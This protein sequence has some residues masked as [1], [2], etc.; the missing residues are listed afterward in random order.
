[1]PPLRGSVGGASLRVSPLAGRGVDDAS[2]ALGP[3]Q[4]Y[5][6][7]AGVERAFE[8]RAHDRREVLRGYLVE[9]AIAGD[10][11]VVDEDVDLAVGVDGRADDLSGLVEISD[12]VVVGGRFSA[13]LPDERDDLIGGGYGASC[14]VALDAGVV[15]DDLGALGSEG[16]G[17][18]SAYAATGAGND[19]DLALQASTSGRDVVF[20]HRGSPVSVA[21]KV[22]LGDEGGFG[23]ARKHGA[24]Q[25]FVQFVERPRRA[26]ASFA[27]EGARFGGVAVAGDFA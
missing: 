24:G 5:S 26:V 1:M 9:E 2:R 3:H 12:G 4:R 20:W 17:V 22:A 10:A 25:Q 16:Y 27:V 13:V 23:L 18:R 7:A 15:D 14:A 11:C 6:V 19:G 8:V 21:I